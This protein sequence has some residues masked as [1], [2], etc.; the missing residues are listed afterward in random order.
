MTRYFVLVT[1]ELLPEIEAGEGVPD[2]FR[3]V[4][5]VGQESARVLRCEVEDDLAP[6]YLA[7]RLVDVT[8][9]AHY[10]RDA[11][12]TRVSVWGRTVIEED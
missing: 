4:R 1:D 11:T 5:V 7:G 8:F 12:V 3:L 9:R 10:A 2:F 6:A